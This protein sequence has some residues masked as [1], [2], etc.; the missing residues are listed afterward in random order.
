MDAV[1]SRLRIGRRFR[2]PPG[3]A[4]GGFASGSLAAMLGGT[5]DVE[6]SLR[7]SVPLNARS[8]SAMTVTPSCSWT[9]T[10]GCSPRRARQPP[11]SR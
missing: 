5:V 6:V 10:A 2:G 9:T 1:R 3:V 7:R 4:N 8:G 11:R